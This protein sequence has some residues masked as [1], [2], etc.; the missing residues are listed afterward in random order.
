M[1]RSY[2]ESAK[3]VATALGGSVARGWADEFSD[4]EV[5]VFWQ[6]HPSDDERVSAVERSGGSVDVRWS[7]DLA[8]DEWRAAMRRTHGEVGQL[9]PYEDDEWS[10]HYYVD[11]LN[12]GVSGFLVSTV[13]AWIADLHRGVPND[14]AEMIA[15][16]LRA[17]MPVTGGE[18]LR[19]WMADLEPYPE[20]L[21][22]AVIEKWLAVDERW[23]AIDQLAARGDRPAFDAVLVAMQRRLV[24]LL[25]AANG[26]YLVDPKPKWTSTLIALC[27]H[28]PDDCMIRL[29]QVQTSSPTVAA[30]LLQDLFEDTLQSIA[31]QFPTIDVETARWLYRH[32]R[33]VLE[34]PPERS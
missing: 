16:T 11:G 13:D 8:E 32:R 14:D 12:V 22:R 28:R 3:V 18:V 31:G 10:E 29:E 6:Q 9:W 21:A 23:W 5:F 34:R 2:S 33:K 27:E 30:S 24:R 15:S 26:L 25:M 1:C 17:G 4:V 7:D 19:N 20:A